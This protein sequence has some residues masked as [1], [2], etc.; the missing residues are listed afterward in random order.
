[1][2]EVSPFRFSVAEKCALA[3]S[4]LAGVGTTLAVVR[5]GTGWA[6]LAAIP[7]AASL[8]FLAVA[9]L[10]QRGRR[11]VRESPP[12]MLVAPDKARVPVALRWSETVPTA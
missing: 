4:A 8:C 1:M 3:A 2:R 6:A 5:P 10:R 11:A 12:R 7:F 9:A